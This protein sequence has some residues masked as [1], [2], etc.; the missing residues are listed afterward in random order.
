LEITVVRTFPSWYSVGIDSFKTTV[1]DICSTN[2]LTPPEYDN[3][4]YNCPSPGVYNFHFVFNNFGTRESWYAGW[5]GYTMGVAVHFKHE[6]GGSDYAT[7]QLDVKVQNA[8]SAAFFSVA[9]L[10]L[11]GLMA[12]LFLRRRRERMAKDNQKSCEDGSGEMTTG[13]ELVHDT[14]AV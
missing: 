13:F 6:G 11:T 4:S 14:S 8:T 5:V 7:C 2:T 10:G 9:S 1:E 3:S 12:G